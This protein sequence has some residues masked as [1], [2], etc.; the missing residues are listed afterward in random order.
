MFQRFRQEPD[1]AGYFSKDTIAALTT[2][3][4][5]TINIVRVSGEAAFA[6]LK[7][8]TGFGAIT[9]ADAR[10]L[11]LCQLRDQGAHLIDQAMVVYFCAPASFTGEDCVE[12]HLHGSS[13]IA[14]R[15]LES[16]SFFGIRQAL[17]GE[18]SFRAVR[19]GKMTLPQAEAVA[20]LISSANQGAVELA[21]EKMSGT[22]NRLLADLT[23][24]V[25]QLAS[26]SEAGIDFSDQDIDE[27]SLS[28]LKERI[29]PLQ[30]KLESLGASFYRGACIQ[31]GIRV[32][33]LGMP[34][35]GKSSFFYIIHIVFFCQST[36]DTTTPVFR[37]DRI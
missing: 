17:P 37:I 7:E 10:R 28:R 26:L 19:N 21:L 32:A 1:R 22:Q 14:K 33:L 5:G 18:F 4:G 20:D 3:P 24:G 31:E 8:M 36:V 2:T 27:L 29:L 11:H 30:K 34:N 9:K 6:A 15:L 16:L 35:V 12:F 13:F 25:R 23:E